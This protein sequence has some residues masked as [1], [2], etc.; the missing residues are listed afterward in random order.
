MSI[1]ILPNELLIQILSYLDYWSLKLSVPLVSH[2]FQTLIN[3]PT[4]TGALDRALFRDKPRPTTSKSNENRVQD[5][6]DKPVPSW[7]S[8]YT[9]HPVLSNIIAQLGQSLNDAQVRNRK[10]TKFTKLSK[11]SV[12]DENAI[13]P[14]VRWL[15]LRTGR[16]ENGEKEIDVIQEECCSV[17]IADI[18]EAFGRC[19]EEDYD[20]DYMELEEGFGRIEKIDVALDGVVTMYEMK[21]EKRGSNTVISS[22]TATSSSTG[23]S[24]MTT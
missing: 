13:S 15:V 1:N 14:A 9:V 8:Y 4:K 21:V 17:T 11:L 2:R 24:S 7:S 22:S 10:N 23:T 16:S 18:V 12:K 3:S 20:W 6:L 5:G 19:H